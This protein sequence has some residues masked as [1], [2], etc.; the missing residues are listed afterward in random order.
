[1]FAQ[2]EKSKMALALLICAAAASMTACSRGAKPAG[3]PIANGTW[4][5]GD[6]V[7]TATFANGS[8]TATANDTGETLSQGRYIVKSETQLRIEWQGNVSRTQNS[9]ECTKP[10]TEEMNCQ[11]QNGRNFT[12]RRTSQTT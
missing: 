4:A 3:P 2:S 1:M 11:D 6:G 9:A 8:F 12:L 5:S 7:Y 10:S